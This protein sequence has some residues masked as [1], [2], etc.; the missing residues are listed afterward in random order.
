MKLIVRLLFV[1][2]GMWTFLSESTRSESTRC[3]SRRLKSYKSV[4]TKQKTPPMPRQV[5]PQAPT[6]AGGIP[7]SIG[8]AASD[9]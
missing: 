8:S 5:G 1:L 4:A 2:A 7:M 6:P 3:R 9:R